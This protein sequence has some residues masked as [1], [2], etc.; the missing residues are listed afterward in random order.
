MGAGFRFFGWWKH[1]PVIPSGQNIGKNNLK[2][3]A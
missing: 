2:D 1:I 3:F